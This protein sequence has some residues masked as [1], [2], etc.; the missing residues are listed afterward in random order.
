MAVVVQGRVTLLHRALQLDAVASG[1]LGA[2]L[3]VTSGATGRLLD[4]P[5]ALLLDAGIVMLA[6]AAITGWL[7]T[8]AVVP[9]RGAVAAIVVNL[10]WAIDSVALLVTGW[11]EPNGLGVAFVVVQALAVL[12]LAELQYQGLRRRHT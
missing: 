5:A 11:V 3:V 9:R 12:G 7:G 4:L 10:L 6:W 8:R 2:L 1:V